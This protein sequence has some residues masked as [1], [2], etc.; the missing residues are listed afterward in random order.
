M[1]DIR[2]KTEYVLKKIYKIYL[3]RI[4]DGKT[5]SESKYFGSCENL[6]DNYFL[7]F[8][9]D[10]LHDCINE[11]SEK[12]YL[13]V[14]YGSNKPAEITLENNSIIYFENRY[15]KNV[16]SVLDDLSKLKN[17]LGL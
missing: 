13:K 12:N 17:L 5:E 16:K 9:F 1:N 10:E 4:K 2:K 3:E 6:L 14:E 7:G 11:L 15:S 8:T